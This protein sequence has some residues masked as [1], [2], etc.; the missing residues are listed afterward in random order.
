MTTEYSLYFRPPKGWVELEME[1]VKRKKQLHEALGK[2]RGTVAH[3]DLIIPRMEAEMGAMID[4]AW[5][6]GIRYA[7]GGSERDCAKH[8]Q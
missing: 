3:A 8:D 6:G 2:M 7:I 4:Q 1:P 5:N